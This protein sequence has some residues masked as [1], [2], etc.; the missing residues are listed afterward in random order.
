MLLRPGPQ[1]LIQDLFQA[2]QAPTSFS[3]SLFQSRQAFAYIGFESYSHG[4]SDGWN[5]G[6]TPYL[7]L[8]IL[9]K[10]RPASGS[11]SALTRRRCELGS[12]VQA[13]GRIIQSMMSGDMATTIAGTCRQCQARNDRQFCQGLMTTAEIPI[14][15][16]IPSHK[17]RPYDI[18]C[19]MYGLAKSRI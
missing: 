9:A 7:P 1:G 13:A 2:P 19:S 8:S 5:T 6:D 18:L 15:P 16:G 10:P 17:S 12:L 3:L 4:C 11:A 14:V